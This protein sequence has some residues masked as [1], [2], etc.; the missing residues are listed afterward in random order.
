MAALGPARLSRMSMMNQ[1][2]AI[3]QGA[4]NYSMTRGGWKRNNRKVKEGAR[5]VFV[6]QPKSVLMYDERGQ[7]M[8][9]ENGNPRERLGYFVELAQYRVEDTVDATTGEEGYTPPPPPVDVASSVEGWQHLIP[10]FEADF[11]VRIGFDSEP[12]PEGANG[13]FRYHDR[14]VVVKTEGRSSGAVFR[15]LCHELTHSLLHGERSHDDRGVKEVEAETSA[16]VVCRAMGVAPDNGYSFQ[17]VSCWGG[18]DPDAL[19]K[20]LKESA[21]NI[22]KASTAI[23]TVI[24][25]D[26]LKKEKGGE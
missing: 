9:D 13:F 6:L 26:L 16:A 21:N 15:T 12:M 14:A 17:Y 2:R 1:F 19:D 22:L 8:R 5:P 10:Q 11:K 18:F 4:K 3:A 24:A 7:L 25:P 23:L 20:Q